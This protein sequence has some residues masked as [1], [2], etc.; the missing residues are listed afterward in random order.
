MSKFPPKVKVIYIK[1][2]VIILWIWKGHFWIWKGHFC[3][4]WQKVEGMAPW[5]PDSYVPVSRSIPLSDDSF[6]KDAFQASSFIDVS[7]FSFASII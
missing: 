6:P 7:L 4:V 2:K 3:I 1:V 5:P